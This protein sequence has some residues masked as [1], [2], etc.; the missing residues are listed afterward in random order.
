MMTG[1]WITVLG[2]LALAAATARADEDLLRMDSAFDLSRLRAVGE[3][4]VG[5]ATYGENA[6]L[7]FETGR[8]AEDAGLELSAPEGTWDLS[9][10]AQLIV[11]VRNAGAHQVR[12]Y[13]RAESPGAAGAL[14]SNLL[15]GPGQS[16]CITMEV[17][18][19]KPD[20][21]KVD[22]FGLVCYPWGKAE[23]ADPTANLIDAAHISKI[24]V[25]T[26]QQFQENAIEISGLR[27]VGT[28]PPVT[29][30]AS[31]PAKFLPFIDEYGQYLHADWPGKIHG[32]ED[33]AKSRE[34]EAQDLAAQPGPA[35]WDQYGGWKDGPQLKAT[36]WFYVTKYNGKW[37]LVD[38][39]GKLFFSEG[40][41]CVTSREGVTPLDDRDGW[42]RNLPA[43]DSEFANCFR[44]SRG[45]ARG[46][47]GGRTTTSFDF[48]QANLMR[49]YGEDW[50]AVF[51][52]LAHRRLRSWGFNTMGNW[53][54]PAICA[55]HRT[56]YT[57]TVHFRSRS[58]E[59]SQGWW[60]KFQDV[61]AEDF[62]VQ[63]RRAMAAQA[64]T[65]AN[66]PWCIGYFVGNEMDWGAN[67][68]DQARMTLVSPAEQPAKQVFVADLKAKY[69]SIEKLNAAWGA[70]HASWE[71]LLQSTAVPDVRKAY[72][73][74]AAFHAKTCDTY[75]RIV[76]DAVKEVAP[77]HLYLG[78]RFAGGNAAAMAAAAKYCDVV[79]VN[80]YARTVNGFALPVP[81]D[82]PLIVG[83]FSFWAPD[84][85]FFDGGGLTLEIMADQAHRVRAYEEFVRSVLRHPQFVGCHWFKYVDEPL[86]G[87]GDG[88][89]YQFGFLSIADTPY[90]ETIDAARRIGSELYEYRVSGL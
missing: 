23:S 82:V 3:A 66:D 52:D 19:R 45:F 30:L 26:R 86:S 2:L 77:N 84:R 11:D 78:C 33:F 31:D 38:P 60:G 24:T 74:L 72:D 27:A 42:F 18:H 43:R 59:G 83:E 9:P 39:E 48:G 5:L 76:R 25:L 71:A 80:V 21:A 90:A 49:K 73:D 64:D 44:S 81:A 56:P 68:I 55:Q 36:G 12:V 17:R 6:A 69:G 16:G 41:D 53:S 10:F 32:P 67:D 35:G 87:R 70:D 20:W 89:N 79:S 14:T 58:L 28:R 8:W 37:W 47:Y 85:G 63:V 4:T 40:M 57:A 7:R 1:F 34:A 75:F 51:A 15:L 62:A 65:T 29:E 46:H 50:R 54:D 13:C 22:L 61:F 88:E